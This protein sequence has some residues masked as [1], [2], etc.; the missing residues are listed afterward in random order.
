MT[1]S[2]EGQHA[3]ASTEAAERPSVLQMDGFITEATPTST[4]TTPLFLSLDAFRAA[5]TCLYTL[6]AEQRRVYLPSKFIASIHEIKVVER[7]YEGDYEPYTKLAV[8]MTVGQK[9]YVLYVG[10]ASWAGQSLLTSLA[11]LTAEQ[12]H[13]AL[14]LK[15]I[16][17]RRTCFF[18][19]AVDVGDGEW[20]AIS[21]N[22]NLLSNRMEPSELQLLAASIDELLGQQ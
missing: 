17:G 8:S 11:Q 9:L 15:A 22:E 1:T 19:A 13:S 12:L 4:S 14:L 20:T 6:D 3:A 18:R 10:L 2:F 16:A 21:I 7:D 5:G